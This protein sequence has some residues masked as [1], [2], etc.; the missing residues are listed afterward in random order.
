[1]PFDLNAV[2][3]CFHVA[4]GPRAVPCD[5]TNQE[6]VLSL[7]DQTTQRF[8]RI[9]IVVNNTGIIQ[10]D[11]MSTTTVEDFVTALDVMF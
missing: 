1:M 2:S 5:V 8:G 3:K 4:E 11:L 9:Y 6:Q 7:V 10:V